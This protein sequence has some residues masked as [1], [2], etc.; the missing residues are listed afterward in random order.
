MVSYSI[1]NYRI[2]WQLWSSILWNRS[3]LFLN[4]IS[5]SRW[6]FWSKMFHKLISLSVSIVAIFNSCFFYRFRYR[7]KIGIFFLISF[8]YNSLLFPCILLYC[9]A[10]RWMLWFNNFLNLFGTIIL[11][12]LW[13]ITQIFLSISLFTSFLLMLHIL[14]P[15]IVFKYKEFLLNLLLSI[16][17]YLLNSF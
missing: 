2:G 8:N 13:L 9:I 12:F 5:N 17:R 3:T 15:Q 10:S 4:L 1:K 7:F 6:W 14:F 16:P 11:H